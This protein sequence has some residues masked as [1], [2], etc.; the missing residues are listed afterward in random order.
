M[1][2]EPWQETAVRGGDWGGSAD[3]TAETSSSHLEER[4]LGEGPVR[5]NALRWGT[6]APCGQKCREALDMEQGVEGSPRIR[7]SRGQRRVGDQGQ[8]CPTHCR[9]C[10]LLPRCREAW[11]GTSVPMPAG[12]QET[13]GSWLGIRTPG[14]HS[15]PT[16]RKVPGQD[17]GNVS[18]NKFSR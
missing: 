5:A 16:Q 18:F 7:E 3:M 8:L 15:R 17:H 14:P 6:S 2:K 1:K 11:T 10:C 4:N 9:S 13:L 12:L